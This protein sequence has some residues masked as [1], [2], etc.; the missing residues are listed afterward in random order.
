MIRRPGNRAPLAPPRYA[1]NSTLNSYPNDIF[2]VD[3]IFFKN[4]FLK[5]QLSI[6][7]S[8]RK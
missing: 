3:K 6:P 2:E 8:Q 5:N 1:S 4:F 7:D